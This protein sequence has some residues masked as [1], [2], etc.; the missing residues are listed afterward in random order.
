MAKVL[1]TFLGTNDYLPCNYAMVGSTRPVKAVRFVQEALAEL[2]CQS[3]TRKDRILVF[4]T[5]EAAAKNWHDGG[6][7][8]RG[9]NPSEG[10][11][12]RL[13]A[14]RKAKRIRCSVQPVFQVPTGFT[15]EEIWLIFGQ[16]LQCLQAGDVVT[17]DITHSFRS[18]P[19][20]AMSFLAYARLT[21]KIRLER[22]VYGAF[23]VL[24]SP[25]QVREMRLE[26]RNAPIVD[27]TEVISLLDWTENVTAFLRSGDATGI[28]QLVGE[29]KRRLFQRGSARSAQLEALVALSDLSGLLTSFT[30]RI[31]TARGQKIWECTEKEKL[32]R[33]FAEAR[34]ASSYLPPLAALWDQIEAVFRPFQPGALANGLEAAHWCVEKGLVP[35]AYTLI[36]E[37]L[38]TRVLL[39]AGCPWNDLR[40]RD[41]ARYAYFA[42]SSGADGSDFLSDSS[43]VRSAFPSILSAVRQLPETVVKLVGG[44]VK[45]R[46]NDIN[47]GGFINDAVSAENLFKDVRSILATL[48]SALEASQETKQRDPVMIHDTQPRR[49]PLLFNHTLTLEQEADARQ[50]WGIEEFVALPEELQSF[51]SQ[52]P[53]AGLL[54]IGSL[55]QI[56]HWAELNST[57]GDP[58]L[59]QGDFGAVTYVVRRLQALGRVPVY[60]TTWRE[61]TENIEPGGSVRIEH[62]FRHVAFRA[63]PDRDALS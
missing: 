21:R 39:A 53:P 40:F 46:R 22:I 51:W 55:E 14:L 59:V 56:I 47:H 16:L 10:L 17:F 54:P 2:L 48:D 1:V 25:V 50:N 18:I 61:A 31:R 8:R 12:S 13:S 11:S 29:E 41:A 15:P 9:E 57:E 62:H 19:I 20:L 6:Q 36:Q 52:V 63:Y 24:G 27:V 5:E 38:L 32:E 35:Q 33:V 30:N 45:L 26:D 37:F 3:W 28:H 7:Q 4:L 34:G 49:M 43:A 58:V 44:I 42:L 60:A 23:E